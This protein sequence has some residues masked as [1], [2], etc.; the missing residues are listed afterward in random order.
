M[1]WWLLIIII[2][3]LYK[4]KT[5]PTLGE[6]K[7]IIQTIYG[8]NPDGSLKGNCFTACIASILGLSIEQVPYFMASTQRVQIKIANNWLKQFNLKLKMIPYPTNLQISNFCL[9]RGRSPRNPRYFHM[10]VWKDNKI[11]HDPHP[12][13]T[14]LVGNPTHLIYFTIIN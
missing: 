4:K 2:Y 1:Y 6:F 9:A 10:V 3:Y 8:Q 14:G 12:D 7:P 13:Q 5:K 11:I